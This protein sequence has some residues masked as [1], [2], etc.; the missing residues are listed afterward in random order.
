MGFFSKVCSKT[1]LPVVHEMRGYPRLQ[2]VVA[3]APDGSVTVGLYDG[4][5]SVGGVDIMD[6]WDETKFVLKWAYK[7]EKYAD[8][9]KS[10][11]E[12]GQGHFMSDLFLDFCDGLA[13]NQKGLKSHKAYETA[14]K[15]LARW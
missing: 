15:N 7:G 5:G 9:P 11:N 10:K 3:L 13:Y 6:E 2:E 12:M 4:Y 14:F 8:L 1:H